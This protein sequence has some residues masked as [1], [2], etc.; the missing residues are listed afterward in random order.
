MAVKYSSYSMGK[1]LL[2]LFVLV[3]FFA[4]LVIF[5][6]FYLQVINGYSITQK[7][8]TQW[9]RDL[10]LTATRGTIT[11][12]NGVVLASSYTT[13]DVYVRPAD[14]EDA[15]EVSLVLSKALELEFED[16]YEKVSK[17]NYS[18]IKIKSGIEK[19][20]VQEILK[21][22]KSGIFFTTNTERNYAYDEMLCQILGFV[23]SDGSGQ[24]GLESFYNTYLS[25]VDGV[26]LVESDLKGTTISGSTTY[27]E[28]PINGLNLSLTIDF[29]LQNEVEKIAKEAMANTGAKGVSVIITDPSNGDVLS[30]VSLPSYNLND[31]PRDDISMLNKMSRATTI[32]DTFEPG[33]TFKPI[34]AA[35]ALEEKLTS[36]HN[37]YY[38]GGYRI[39]NGVRINC[40]RRSGHGSQSLEQGLMN[41][42][43]CVFMD[44][45]AQIGLPKFYDYLERFGF[46]SALGIDFPGEV[47]A[48]LMPQSLVTDADLARM[49]FG[50]TI[51]I[52]S[53]EMVTGIGAVINGGYVY[54]PHFINNIFTETGKIVYERKKTVV[55]KVLGENTS[56]QMRE[57]LLSVVEKGGG[58]YAKVEGFPIMGGK[59]GTAQKYENGAV[60]QG[61]Y[62]ASF[63]GFAPYDD[64]KYLCYVVV[65]EPQGAYYGGVVAAPIAQK[66]FTKIFEFENFN[67]SSSEP[68]EKNIELPTFIGMTISQAAAT[69]AGLK[70]QYLVQGDGDY[71]TG[72]VAAPGTMVAEGDIVLLIF[73]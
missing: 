1:R 8:L 54:Q 52:S 41:S 11:D 40:A 2:A 12:R 61:K 36:K 37:Y 45:I 28:N 19:S 18:E 10:P 42:C 70:L 9:L 64:P 59:T 21:E 63:L 69:C 22:F 47:S 33:S 25:G 67:Q 23:S 46:T 49:G 26:S 62:I 24:A 29:K 34:V 57:M 3:A 72:Q 6:I 5:R 60:A 20:V 30:V 27:Y 4:C 43:N 17:R 38:C 51:A 66:I 13:Y 32:V 58:K 44:L 56:K 73:E 53:L 71:V 65:D 7:G 31:I 16:V 35:I 48:V 55:S 39:V 68:Q 15:N 14:V 50:Q